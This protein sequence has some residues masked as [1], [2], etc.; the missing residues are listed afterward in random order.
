[1]LERS[2]SIGGI[3]TVKLARGYA[4]DSARPTPFALSG[5]SIAQETHTLSIQEPHD[6]NCAALLA[7]I[8]I[9][10]LLQQD[11]RPTFII[12]IADPANFQPRC[13]CLIFANVALRSRP[14]LLEQVRGVFDDS[15][16]NPT[17][18][19]AFKQFKQWATSH[20]EDG[21]ALAVSPRTYTYAGSVWTCSTLRKRVRVIACNPSRDHAVQDNSSCA[22]DMQHYQGLV[23]LPKT[24]P[25]STK[26][27]ASGYF[28]EP[29]SAGFLRSP[30][31][32][33]D[34]TCQDSSGVVSTH[35]STNCA[36]KPSGVTN[37][38]IESM[39]L[40]LSPRLPEVEAQSRDR[41][42]R[43]GSNGQNTISDQGFFDW[44]KLPESSIMPPHIQFARSVNW[45]ATSLGPI[46][47][48]D[49]DLR[50]MCNLIMA[51]PH[52]A[53]MYW[54]PDLIAIYNEAYVLLAGNKHPVLMGQKY[55][56]AWPEIWD[57]VEDVFV[58]ARSSAQATMKDDDQLFMNRDGFLEETYFSWS[59][60]PL[61]GADGSVVGL[62]NPAF[63]KTRRKIAERRMLTLREIGERTAAAREVS[64]FWP[65]LLQGLEYNELDAPFVLLYSVAEDCESDTSSVHSSSAVTEKTLILEGSLGVPTGHKAAPRQIDLRK[66]TQGFAPVFRSA[67]TTD[68]PIILTEKN[69]TLDTE[70]LKGI[71]WR[72]YGDPSSTVVI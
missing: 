13:I 22:S 43:S 6:L 67:V 70:L 54:G 40:L 72:G 52:P 3:R 17:G 21:E 44:T 1:M 39:E 64:R 47:T 23:S 38:D 51:S 19:S 45:A 49:A 66:C 32:T 57:A 35:K 61:I 33:E 37:G 42:K 62:Y 2:E 65:L 27:E 29:S 46:E 41:L 4:T 59:I 68:K 50:A 8:G 10:E 48:W 34:S 71:E 63:E 16:P 60:I 56:E 18:V 31:Y 69:G 53:A 58:T 55:R 30:I 11:E 28:D 36:V 12:D 9:L 14:G 24:M 20:V 5:N 7:Q 25:E 26:Q 15:P